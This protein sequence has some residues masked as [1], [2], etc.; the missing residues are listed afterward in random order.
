[1][2]WCIILIICV[3]VA[4]FTGFVLGYNFGKRLVVEDFD[5]ILRDIVREAMESGQDK[6]I[7]Y[8]IT[9]EGRQ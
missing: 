3:A 9:T 1:M 4:I 5:R 6:S 8:E 7:T 2:I